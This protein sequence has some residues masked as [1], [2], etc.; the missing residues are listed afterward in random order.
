MRRMLLTTTLLAATAVSATAAE[1]FR[2]GSETNDVNRCV[3]L[4]HVA[5]YIGVF[6]T[7][8]IP[9][10]PFISAADAEGF[11]GWVAQVG[12]IGNQAEWAE[13]CITTLRKF[14]NQPRHQGWQRNTVT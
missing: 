10:R 11:A 1:P 4:L 13:R 2:L 12:L 8:E 9:N 14:T 3:R 6:H 7:D 5:R